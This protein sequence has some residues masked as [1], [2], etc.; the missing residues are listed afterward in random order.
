M[1]LPRFVLVEQ[2]FPDRA[3]PNIKERVHAELSRSGFA[4]RI[5]PG[6]RVAIGVGSRGISNI[7]TIVKAIIEFWKNAGARPFIFPAMGSHGAATAEGQADVLAHYGIHEATIGAP[8]ISSLDVVSLGKTSEGIDTFMDR[9]AYESDG[10]LLV[11]RVKWHTDFSGSIESGL[12]K[13]LAIGVGKFAGARQYHTFGYRLGLEQVIRSAGSKVLSSGKILGGLA[14]QEGAHHETAGLVAISSSEG[15]EFM[16]AKEESLLNEVKSWKATLPAPEIDILIVDEI[17]KDISGAGMDTKVINRGING[18]YNPFSDI[19]KVH[20][21]YARGLSELTYHSAI[22]IGLAD[23]I[24]DRLL[25]GVNWRPTYLN[26]L[27]ACTPAGVRTP[28]HFASDREV[29]EHIAPT[30]GKTD[31]AEVTYCR[32]RNTLSLVHVSV[33][34]NLLPSLYPSAEPISAPFEAPF[35]RQSDFGDFEAA[36]KSVS[37]YSET[38][39]S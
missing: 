26:S 28:I 36:A 13:M 8:V 9:S 20:R 33:S 14:I 39:R 5:P 24:H 10:I 32:I 11:P 12:F 30:V 4:S 38:A 22:G 37:V 31:F 29:L 18:D 2:V 27:T 3:I 1:N 17:G 23:I 34:E 21:V 15:G 25:D 16:L 19:P 35:T 6:G 7:A